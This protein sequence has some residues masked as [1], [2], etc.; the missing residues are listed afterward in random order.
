MIFKGKSYAINH[1]LCML[2]KQGKDGRKTWIRSGAEC[3]GGEGICIAAADNDAVRVGLHLA[4][5][6]A[7]SDIQ[8]VDCSL[9]TGKQGLSASSNS[10]AG[11]RLCSAHDT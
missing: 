5:Q 4:L 6:G 3:K 2:W 7:G 8:V 10:V 1:I 11:D 9:P